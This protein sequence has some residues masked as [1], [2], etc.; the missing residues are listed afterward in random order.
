MQIFQDVRAFMSISGA[1][2]LLAMFL[3]YGIGTGMLA[4]MNAV[5]LDESVGLSKEQI[6]AVFAVSLFCN[7][8]ITITVGWFSDRLRRKK[9]L[10]LA[11]AF[12]CII[13]LAV[14]MNASDFRSALIGMT[15]AVAPSGLIMGQLFGMARSHFARKAGELVEMAQLW[16]RASFS[17]GFFAGLLLGANIFLIATFRGVLWGNVAGYVCLAVLLL[18]YKETA[19]EPGTKTAVRG[20]PFSLVMLIALLLLSCADA[21]RGLYL[22]LVV[23]KLFG[24]P[25]VMSYIWSTQAV[26]E[27][28]FMTLGGYWA[29][30]YGS[31]KI[32]FLGGCFALAA[33]L[34]YTSSGSLPVFFAVQPLYSFFVSILAGVAMG[35]VQRM[36]LSRTGFGASLYVF[37]TQTA[38]LIGYFLPLFI[39]GITPDIFYIPSAL[40]TLSLLIIGIVL[41]RERGSKDRNAK[42]PSVVNRAV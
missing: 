10:P 5:Y 15:I 33:Y 31:K 4:P 8:A 19:G 38:S 9:K 32:I 36:F 6:V 27:L 25:E 21:I 40:V 18:A 42:K 13:G 30:R 39:Q 11:A 34:T 35:Y 7:I 41:Y 3:L 20:E 23:L 37:I 17:V 14:Y 16:L 24:K 22:Q 1:R 26:F 28:F 29:A 12:L 2:I